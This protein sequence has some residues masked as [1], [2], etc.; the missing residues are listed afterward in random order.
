MEP[1]VAVKA[2]ERMASEI[3]AM[4]SKG[5]RWNDIAAVRDDGA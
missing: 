3:H 5:Y 4:R 2:I 1:R